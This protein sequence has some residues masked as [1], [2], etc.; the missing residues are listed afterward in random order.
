MSQALALWR[1]GKDAKT[2]SATNALPKQAIIWN[3]KGYA[4]GVWLDGSRLD[5]EW[6]FGME[7]VPAEYRLRL[8][9]IGAAIAVPGYNDTHLRAWERSFDLSGPALAFLARGVAA[10]LRDAVH[11]RIR[12]DVDAGGSFVPGMSVTPKTLLGALWI[13][14]FQDV[15]GQ[16]RIAQCSYCQ[17]P[18]FVHKDPRWKTCSEPCMRGRERVLRDRRGGLSEEGI[19]KK[20]NLSIDVVRKVLATRDAA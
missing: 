13:Q 9:R 16:R 20:R 3:P 12:I 5:P 10:R 4:P 18:Y 14:L 2:G 6:A 11:V 15:I 8:P 19:A 1:L 17:L 7:D